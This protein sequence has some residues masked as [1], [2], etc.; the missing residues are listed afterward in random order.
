MAAN[1]HE[2]SCRALLLSTTAGW[3]FQRTMFIAEDTAA[4]ISS[5]I[6]QN[7]NGLT[8]YLD[9]P[10]D[11]AALTREYQNF[12]ALCKPL[13]RIYHSHQGEAFFQSAKNLFNAEGDAIYYSKMPPLFSIPEH[14]AAYLSKRSGLPDLF[15]SWKESLNSFTSPA[16]V[17]NT[18][19]VILTPELVMKNTEQV[20]LPLCEML[21]LDPTEYTSAFYKQHI[22]NLQRMEKTDK[23]LKIIFKNEMTD[24]ILLYARE[25]TGTLVA[26]SCEPNMAFS[27]NEPNMSNAFWEYLSQQLLPSNLYDNSRQNVIP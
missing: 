7:S 14:I 9:D 6:R 23:R 12:L 5:S 20:H 2:R 19:V 24:K 25:H 21:K 26:T 16:N 10:K 8:L 15:R 13:M 17:Y 4:I 22:E 3:L 18:T 27:I 11:I 1:I